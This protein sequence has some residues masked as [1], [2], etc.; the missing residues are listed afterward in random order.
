MTSVMGEKSIGIRRRMAHAVQ[1]AEGKLTALNLRSI[2]GSLYDSPFSLSSEDKARLLKADVIS[3]DLFDTLIFRDFSDP[4]VIF[5]MCGRALNFQGFKSARAGAEREIR[6]SK[7]EEVTLEE[8]YA[9]LE[10]RYG[11]D[12]A[13]GMALECALELSHCRPNEQMQRIWKS[14]LTMCRRKGKTCVIISD[15]YLPEQQVRR[16]LEKCGYEG[17]DALYLSSSCGKKKADGSL[18]RLVREQLGPEKKYLHIGDHLR[19]DME[20]AGQAGFETIYYPNIHARGLT[21]ERLQINAVTGSLY[22]SLVNRKMLAAAEESDAAWRFGYTYFGIVVYGYCQWLHACR[23]AY[24]ADAVWFAARDMKVVYRVYRKLFPEEKAEYVAAS[25]LALLKANMPK[26]SD[27][28]FSNLAQ[29]LEEKKAPAQVFAAMRLEVLSDLLRGEGV[30]VGVYEAGQSRKIVEILKKHVS[31]ISELLLDERKAATACFSALFGE[32]SG[33]EQA[34]NKRRILFADLNGRCTSA[35]AVQDLLEAAG[36]PCDVICAQLYT[37]TQGELFD[38]RASG[39]DVLV[40]LFSAQHERSHRNIFTAHWDRNAAVLETVFTEDKGTLL[41]YRK[42]GEGS[43]T[44]AA[45]DGTRSPEQIHQGIR[46]FAED[47]DQVW[48]GMS[49]TGQID[50]RIAYTAMMAALE[51]T[52]YREKTGLVMGS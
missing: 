49:K 44:Y 23:L 17:Y 15:M 40:W 39:E 35:I 27:M 29:A 1:R 48:K 45:G 6:A 11:I 22:C 34:Q 50:T 25:R 28:F 51:D 42:N 8:I 33:E 5:D 16:M 18:F 41:S 20:M 47:F 38:S 10:K 26:M 12:P 37:T 4:K 36:K 52:H 2:Y 21:P 32:Q 46:D 14:I 9:L 13:A 43:L 31:Q 3:F 24:D 30:D 19:S 7:E